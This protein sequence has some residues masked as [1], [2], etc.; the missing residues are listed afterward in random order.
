MVSRYGVV[1]I[2]SFIGARWLAA[3]EYT[4]DGTKIF[5]ID[6]WE[7]AG[8]CSF[9]DE[10]AGCGLEFVTDSALFSVQ[11]ALQLQ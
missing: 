1:F 9:S 6:C 10:S 11:F 2:C 4:T 3:T 5:E 7:L 8:S